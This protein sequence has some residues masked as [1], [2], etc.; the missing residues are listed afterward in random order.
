MLKFYPRIFLACHMRHVRDPQTKREIS[1]H[2]ASILD[3]LDD[4]EPTSVKLLAKHMGVTHST[5]SLSIERLVR[6]GYVI[7]ER[8]PEDARRACL[9]LTAQGLRIKRMEK[10]LEPALVRSMLAKLSPEELDLALRGLS[11]L[12]RAAQEQMHQR[13]EKKQ[14]GQ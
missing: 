11:L 3:H 8:D 5:M 13:V 4:K 2:Q 14:R 7:R 10:V 9:R 1:Q 12:G 6:G